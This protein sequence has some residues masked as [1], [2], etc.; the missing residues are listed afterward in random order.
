[1]Y[2]KLHQV[3]YEHTQTYS[4]NTHLHCNFAQSVSKLNTDAKLFIRLILVPYHHDLPNA[5]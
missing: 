4:Y 2:D 5:K 3:N 1:M